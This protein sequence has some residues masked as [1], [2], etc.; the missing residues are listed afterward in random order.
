MWAP[1][2]SG[3]LLRGICPFTRFL[4]SRSPAECQMSTSELS[5]RLVVGLHGERT[6]PPPPRHFAAEESRP[7]SLASCVPSLPP[8]PL[9]PAFSSAPRD[10]SCLI[11]RQRPG[12]TASG[13]FL[14]IILRKFV[15]RRP[16]LLFTVA[17]RFFFGNSFAIR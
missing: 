2:F 11:R 16:S 6:T 14:V 7:G 12:I 13:A 17:T 3:N 8:C 4:P 1:L 9:S 10:R 5:V 15:F